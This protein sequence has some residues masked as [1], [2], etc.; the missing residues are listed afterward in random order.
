M[1]CSI[2]DIEINDVSEVQRISVKVFR[3][4]KCAHNSFENSYCVDFVP[5]SCI[6]KICIYLYI[7]IIYMYL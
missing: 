1:N 2:T 7:A 3:Y 6:R 5:L 4:V